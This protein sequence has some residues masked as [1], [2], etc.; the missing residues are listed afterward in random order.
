[1]ERT[2]NF[3]YR[4]KEDVEHYISKLMDGSSESRE[5]AREALIR[6]GILMKNGKPKETIVSWK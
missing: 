3:K 5:E 6:T 4:T 1:M 2:S